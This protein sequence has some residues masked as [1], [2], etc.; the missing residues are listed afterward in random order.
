[1]EVFRKTANLTNGGQ[2]V[3]LQDQHTPSVIV[4]FNKVTNSTTTTTIVA[5]GDRAA[6][7]T[8]VTGVAVGSYLV[9]FHPASVRFMTATVTGIGSSPT[10]DLDTP[11]DFAFPAGTFVDVAITNMKVDGSSTP[12]V[13]GLR[14]TG[15]PLGVKLTV[16]ITRIIIS[17][18]TTSAVD[19]SKF[20]N[21][22]KLTNGLLMR[23]RDGTYDNIFN[24][25][26]NRELAGIMYDWSPYGA[27]NPVQGIDGFA[28]RLTF[29]G[30]SKIGVTKRLAL[31]ED[32]E[33]H[34]QDDLLTAQAGDTIT[35]LEV[36]AEGH[37]VQ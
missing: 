21:L 16:D 5:I 34:I 24:I 30:Q 32:L 35:V 29:A 14:G 25:K 23:K 3:Q 27:T 6:T 1:M 26:D 10:F 8:S 37:I 17:C 36:I 2:D 33:I 19:L 9:F 7:L 15:T 22:A 12:Q 13:F 28:S 4:K 20:A 18:I 11:F 31:G